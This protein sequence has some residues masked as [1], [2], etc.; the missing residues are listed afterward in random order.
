MGL[1][2]NNNWLKMIKAKHYRWDILWFKI[3]CE[4]FYSN[5][6]TFFWE[7]I[8]SVMG[9]HNIRW[10]LTKFKWLACHCIVLKLEIY[11]GSTRMQAIESNNH[12]PLCIVILIIQSYNSEQV[13]TYGVSHHQWPISVMIAHWN[14]F[15]QW[16][17]SNKSLLL[18][19]NQG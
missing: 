12:A 16:S 3:K 6:A 8:T 2:E 11:R 19:I 15:P 17:R 1:Y 9:N 18:Y 10:N 7:C 13:N 14:A 4:G 5:H